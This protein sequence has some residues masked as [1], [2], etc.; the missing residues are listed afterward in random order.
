MSDK[1]I[2][3]DEIKTL[4]REKQNKIN[5]MEAMSVKSRKKLELINK[6]IDAQNEELLQLLVNITDSEQDVSTMDST[7]VLTKKNEL[8]NKI[9]KVLDN[10]RKIRNSLAEIIR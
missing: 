1:D 7:E 9:N 4:L 3:L 6:K 10:L 5:D 2:S 8:T